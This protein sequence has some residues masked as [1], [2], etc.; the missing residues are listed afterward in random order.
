M[1]GHKPV[2]LQTLEVPILRPGLRAVVD[3]LADLS[4]TMAI[5]LVSLKKWIVVPLRF[6]RASAKVKLGMVKYFMLS[7]P[8]LVVL[9]CIVW[10]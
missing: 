9:G 10:Q 7:T 2:A 8:V 6:A 1:S 4:Q 5:L 3:H